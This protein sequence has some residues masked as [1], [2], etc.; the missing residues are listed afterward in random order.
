MKVKVLVYA[1]M[2]VLLYSLL[3]NFFIGNATIQPV[4]T[5]LP[6]L[7]EGMH[8]ASIIEMYG[9]PYVSYGR[10]TEWKTDD[11]IILGCFT[12]DGY[13]SLEEYGLC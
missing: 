3:F 6:E 13:E 9:S 7:S 8:Y 4:T 2:I 5:E 1:T 11:W 10:I 12:M